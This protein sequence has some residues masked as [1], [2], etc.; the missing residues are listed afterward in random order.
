M[1]D[2]AKAVTL[3]K[4]VV[5]VGQPRSGSTLITRILNENVGLFVI[6]DFYVLQKIDASDLWGEL[7]P[8][9]M[10]QVAQWIFDKIETRATQEVGKTL[11]Q[12]I[13]LDAT[14]VEV[15]RARVTAPFPDGSRWSDVL[16]IMM[17]LGATLAGCTRWGYNTPQD[18]LHLGR[19]FDAF[20][21]LQVIFQLRD[22]AAVLRS[23]KNVSGRHHDAA[24]YNP[25]A[26]GLAWR[27]ASENFSRWHD[28]RPG[29]I[30]FVRYEDI[31]AT[32][33]DELSRIGVFLNVSFPNIN[34]RNFGRNSSFESSRR[35]RRVTGSELWLC[36]RM[37][38]KELK[39]RGFIEGKHR[40]DI[41][42]LPEIAR[43]AS[44]STAFFFNQMMKPERRKRILRLLA[45]FAGRTPN[46][47]SARG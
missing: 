39:I 36:E 43:V 6:N 44:R 21:D 7:S 45:H 15:L 18:H 33:F 12:S 37:I 27:T 41:S 34:L 24:R 4:P 20:P 38:G 29:Q 42:D 25:I 11:S 22:P 1:T 19:L 17:S 31:V 3:P 10:R 28:V 14:Q 16:A 46:P 26:I 32:T 2:I 9:Q 47:E 35:E 5:V 23:Y 13:D 8:K 40:P 30:L